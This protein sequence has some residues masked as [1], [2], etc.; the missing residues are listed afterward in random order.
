[1]VFLWFFYMFAFFAFSIA[2]LVIIWLIWRKRF[3]RLTEQVTYLAARIQD[4]EQQISLSQAAPPPPKPHVEHAPQPEVAPSVAQVKGAEAWGQLIAERPPI[5]RIEPARAVA[6]ATPAKAAPPRTP[7]MPRPTPPAAKL[8]ERISPNLAKM[9]VDA[10]DWEAVIR[11]EAP[12][13]K[14]APPRTPPMPRP[15]PPA[16]KLRERISPNLA[17]MGVDAADWEA[18]IGGKWLNKI[19]IVVFVIGVALFLG[20][21]LRYM[22]PLGRVAT[23]VVTS[24]TL[25]FG[26]VLLERVEK[27][28]LFAKPLIGG[29]W[30]LLYFTGYA[31]HNIEVSKIIHDPIRG[32][33]LLAVIAGGMILHSLKYRSQVVTGIAYF[34]G[35]LTVAI[36][37]LTGFA[38][39][40]S[41]ILA[42]SLV[43]I[44]RGTGSS[45]LG[46]FGVAATYLN[47]LLWL[48]YRMGGPA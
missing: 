41:A 3:K 37:P 39:V 42:A 6:E 24:L 14:A 23:G 22:G 47:H 33:A 44:L 20:Y 2:P 32:I 36:S 5:P 9:G 17:K 48:E 29:G 35:F 1:M 13:A 4:L 18:V 46:L 38:L 11:S 28:S 10:A 30:A 19:G 40:A 45:A 25:L 34:L 15:T 16:A 27:Y 26:G 12:P 21:S 43:A 7:P 8:R 31:A